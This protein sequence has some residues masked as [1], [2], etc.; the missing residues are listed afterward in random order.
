MKHSCRLDSSDTHLAS[1]KV[2][3][4]I[5]VEEDGAMH[6]KCFTTKMMDESGTSFVLY[7]C[8]LIESSENLFNFLVDEYSRGNILLKQAFVVRM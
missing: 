8:S 6:G 7:F 2:L 3:P 4:V 1:V 5:A